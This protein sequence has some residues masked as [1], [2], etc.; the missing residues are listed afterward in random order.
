MSNIFM[1][2]GKVF[3]NKICKPSGHPATKIVTLVRRVEQI[4]KKIM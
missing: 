4:V 3:Q 2:W 1:K